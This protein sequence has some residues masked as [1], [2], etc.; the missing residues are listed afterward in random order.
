[1]KDIETIKSYY[2][3]VDQS[4]SV[5]NNNFRVNSGVV[6]QIAN[7]FHDAAVYDREGHIPHI[8]KEDIQR[9][10]CRKR[11]LAGMHKISS[12]AI[13]RGIDMNESSR[14]S[15]ELIPNLSECRT[16]KVEGFFY[17]KFY[18]TQGNGYFRP[19]KQGYHIELGFDDYWVLQDRKVVYRQSDIF[20]DLKRCLIIEGGMR[21]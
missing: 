9:F 20:P 7:L 12:I 17:G 15:L 1:M 6:E 21:Y 19:I 10:F 11:S 2:D 8:G 16:V 14:T 3:L 4:T 5:E 18:T 13:V